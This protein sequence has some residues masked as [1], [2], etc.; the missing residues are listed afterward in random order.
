MKLHETH[1]INQR[2]SNEDIR[3][4][5]N[6]GKEIGHGRYG[7]VRLAQKNS[8]PKKRFAV[9]SI[10]RDKIKTDIHLLE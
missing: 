3:K 10:S 8:H 6:I 2:I 7:T 1:E 9:K 4:I 5:Y